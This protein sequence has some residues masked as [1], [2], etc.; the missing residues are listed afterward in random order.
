L[1]D[2]ARLTDER[3]ASLIAA[4]AGEIV[5]VVSQDPAS[6]IGRAF[7]QEYPWGIYMTR[8]DGCPSE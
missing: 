4:L 3:E 8:A 7:S 6:A 2:K 5:G 1:A